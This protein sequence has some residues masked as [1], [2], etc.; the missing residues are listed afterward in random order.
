VAHLLDLSVKDLFDDEDGYKHLIE[1]DSLI[2]DIYTFFSRS[3]KKIVDLKK[4]FLM[5]N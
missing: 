4:W 2:K 5:Q 3:P 1:F